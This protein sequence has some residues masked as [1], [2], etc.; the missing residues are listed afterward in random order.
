[1]IDSEKTK[2]I[3]KP[4]IPFALKAAMKELTFF[5]V[6]QYELLEKFLCDRNK[7]EVI[8]NDLLIMNLNLMCKLNYKKEVIFHQ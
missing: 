1:V 4:Y 5:P 8:E 7:G 2:N 3:I 6:L